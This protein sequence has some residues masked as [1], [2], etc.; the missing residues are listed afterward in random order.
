VATSRPLRVIDP[1]VDPH[2]TKSGHTIQAANPNY[3]SLI[4]GTHKLGP[5]E[6]MALLPRADGIGKSIN[7]IAALAIARAHS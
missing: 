6:A 3:D 1:G 4:D 5:G 7:D 2:P